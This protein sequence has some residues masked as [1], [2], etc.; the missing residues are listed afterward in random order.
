MVIANGISQFLELNYIGQWGSFAYYYYDIAKVTNIDLKLANDIIVQI[1]P[2]PSPILLAGQL[3]DQS[4]ILA[5]LIQVIVALGVVSPIALPYI[6]TNRILYLSYAD[7]AI[8]I[9]QIISVFLCGIIAQ[10]RYKSCIHNQIYNE[11][12]FLVITG[13]ELQIVFNQ[14]KSITPINIISYGIRQLKAPAQAISDTEINKWESLAWK[15]LTVDNN[16][17]AGLGALARRQIVHINQKNLQK[18]SNGQ[19]MNQSDE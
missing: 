16:Y 8:F 19:P 13:K 9:K 10:A 5:S 4:E 17:D 11:A 14:F 15:V 18:R 6:L 2:L 7:F 12:E 1:N 3:D